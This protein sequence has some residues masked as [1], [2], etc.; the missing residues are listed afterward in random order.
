MD[1][2]TVK[3]AVV[4][5]LGFVYGHRPAHIGV[6]EVALMVTNNLQDDCY[7]RRK[8]LG[9]LIRQFSNAPEALRKSLCPAN[10]ANPGETTS[11]SSGVLGK[12]MTW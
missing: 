6:D 5:H 7:R 1:R 2:L 11:R 3:W 10:P 8:P 4:E 9:G 12:C